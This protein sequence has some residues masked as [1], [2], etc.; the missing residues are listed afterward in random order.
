[1]EEL[2]ILTPKTFAEKYGK[3]LGRNGGQIS[4]A[5]AERW[6]RSKGFPAMKRG[7]RYFAV[8]SNVIEWLKNAHKEDSDV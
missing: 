8:E 2:N 5:T 4:A 7:G 3:T 1:M 6:F